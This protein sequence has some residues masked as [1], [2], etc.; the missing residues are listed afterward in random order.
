MVS[1]PTIFLK[2][3][4]ALTLVSAAPAMACS[5]FF[6]H[7][8]ASAIRA[9]SKPVSVDNACRA[10]NVG[11][12]DGYSLGPAQ[13]LE[14]GRVYQEI[15]G[16]DFEVLIGDCNSREVTILLGPATQVG[17]NTCGPEYDY[18]PLTGPRSAF[19][20]NRGDDLHDLVKQLEEA[21]GVENNPQDLF[22]RFEAK[23]G[24]KHK[25]GRK[26]RVDLLCGCKLYYPDSPGAKL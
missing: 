2:T 7:R 20:L 18:A 19:S 3:V 5:P 10:L 21:G 16:N 12:Y 25:V 6:E 8:S 4:V 15:N 24:K 17:E 14:N 1:T 13:G 26:D 23:N 11:V 22:L 9:E